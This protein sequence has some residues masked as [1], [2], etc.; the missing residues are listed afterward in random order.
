MVYVS[1][2]VNLKSIETGETQ[3]LFAVSGKQENADFAAPEQ[4]EGKSSPEAVEVK[5]E[6]SEAKKRGRKKKNEND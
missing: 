1:K 6:P 2:R 4:M 3:S 5:N